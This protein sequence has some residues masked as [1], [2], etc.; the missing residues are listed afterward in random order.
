MGDIFID[1]EQGNSA[2]HLKVSNQLTYYFGSTDL[3][4]LVRHIDCIS[5]LTNCISQL[6]NYINQLTNYI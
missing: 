2:Q 3:L 1:R 6:T 5:Q 4:H